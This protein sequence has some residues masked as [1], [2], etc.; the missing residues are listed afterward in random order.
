MSDRAILTEASK[1]E[2]CYTLTKPLAREKSQCQMG[3]ISRSSKQMVSF[4]AP[5]VAHHTLLTLI[6]DGSGW[7]KIKPANGPAG[8]VP[9]SYAEI[10][11]KA[12]SSPNDRPV[13]TAASVSTTS[14][15]GSVN[16][17]SGPSAGRKQGPAVAP[18]RGAKKVRHVEALY[19]YDPS[20]EG[21]TAMQEGEKMVLIAP[22]Q[23]DG[24]CEVESKAG[25][26]VVPAG[27]VK[28]V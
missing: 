1:E 5:E 10:S 7:I 17:S 11:A 27:W 4:A 14:L 3:R 18:R 28:E 25:R 9:A 16:S 19:T 22:D 21:E 2:R 26:G 13:S 8:L 20:G 24:W 6:P 15:A 23:G 12:P